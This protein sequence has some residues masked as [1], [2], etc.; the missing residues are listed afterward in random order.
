MYWMPQTEHIKLHILVVNF[1][2]TG[3]ATEMVSR[4]LWDTIKVIRQF[5]RKVLI[6]WNILFRK[7]PGKS[8]DP[9]VTIHEELQI[10]Q[11]K[12]LVQCIFCKVQ[13]TI[14]DYPQVIT[15]ET[16][17][18]QVQ[19]LCSEKSVGT[20]PYGQSQHIPL[21]NNCISHV[22]Q[23]YSL[24]CSTTGTDNIFTTCCY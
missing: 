19:L 8:T 4:S 20:F 21:S 22:S 15:E 13:Y 2:I 1:N 17:R 10:P 6:I 11:L 14:S 24:G 23:V 5:W 12:F 9:D 7:A 18:W 3:V 16:L